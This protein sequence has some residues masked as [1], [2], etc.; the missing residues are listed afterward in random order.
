[1][2]TSHHSNISYTCFDRSILTAPEPCRPKW[3]AFTAV[4]QQFSSEEDD[5]HTGKTKNE[6]VSQ[7]FPAV[8]LALAMSE[9]KLTEDISVGEAMNTKLLATAASI[10]VT[11]FSLL[12]GFAK[13][14]LRNKMQGAD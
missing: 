11:V 10:A 13:D 3:I 14:Y 8:L 2:A 12:G 5:N 1:M 4:C 7:V 9:S 6:V